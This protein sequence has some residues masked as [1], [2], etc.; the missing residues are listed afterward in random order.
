M[1]GV[2]C[3]LPAGAF[4]AFPNVAGLFGRRGPQGPITTPADLATYLLNEAKIAV[5][6]GEPFGSAAHIRLSYATSDEAIRTGM[7][8]MAAA[9]RHLG[10]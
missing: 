9:L 7:D 10:S 8:R 2:R 4:Y 3:A 6:P 5:V 1:P